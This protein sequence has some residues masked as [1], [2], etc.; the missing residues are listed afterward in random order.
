MKWIDEEREKI[1]ARFI[2][3]CT[4]WNNTT[5]IVEEEGRNKF[6]GRFLEGIYY[7]RLELIDELISDMEDIEAMSILHALVGEAKRAV[8]LGKRTDLAWIECRYNTWKGLNGI[9]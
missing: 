5:K 3:T 9:E 7:G 1:F 4:R 8:G 6:P 2:T